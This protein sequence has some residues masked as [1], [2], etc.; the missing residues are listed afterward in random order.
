MPNVI[1]QQRRIK[2]GDTLSQIAEQ[3]LGASNRW[4]EIYA[5]NRDVLADPNKLTPGLDL[6]VPATEA[7]AKQAVA[8][9]KAKASSYLDK[10]APR[11][12]P[13]PAG[14]SFVEGMMRRGWT[15]QEA[16]GA[17]GNAHVESGFKPT[18][19][20]SVPGEHSYG[21]LQW[22]GPRLKGLQNMAASTGRDWT[23]PET[24]MDWINMERSG[25][26][27]EFGGTDERAMY[28]KAL[29]GG[30]P[31]DIAQRFGQYVERPKRL[32]DTLAMRRQAASKYAYIDDI[33]DRVYGG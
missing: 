21:F 31:E 18:I 9:E 16:A 6:K 33:T 29:T 7:V 5:A 17:A 26:S 24:Q 22:N 10:A 1:Y 25:K 11:V 30:T 20:S 13:L 14:S 2:E 4:Q 15:I 3:V 12:D 32:S 27:V 28:S 23:D 8:D 19:K